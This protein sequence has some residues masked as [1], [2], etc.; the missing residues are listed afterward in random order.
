MNSLLKHPYLMKSLR[1]LHALVWRFL[2]K[3]LI[4]IFPRGRYVSSV[5]NARVFVDFRDENYRWYFRKNRFLEQE[6]I[7]LVEC[8]KLR[9][10]RVIVDIGAHWG[11]FPAM[12]DADIERFPE[13][14]HVICIE[15]DPKNIPILR[16]TVSRITRFKVSIIEAAIG[17]VDSVASAF[18]DGGSCLQTY[19]DRNDAGDLVV[20]LRRLDSILR[21]LGVSDKEVTHIKIDIDGYEPS[22]FFGSREWIRQ[23]KPVILTEYWFKGLAKHPKY[24]VADY[25]SLLQEGH[26]VVLCNYP[27]GTY[28]LLNNS[29]LERLNLKTKN[30][31]ANL[32][33]IPRAIIDVD[34]L[35]KNLPIC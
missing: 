23:F 26:H 21:D 19:S 17:E 3:A 11:I 27:G 28:S 30:S 32:L 13:V 1:S 33:L 6:H 24:H 5:C 9:T 15:P 31:V 35:R 12:L 10:P 4:A 22:F 14:S 8:A 29:D 18:R 16:K 34:T 20:P 7:A 25:F 2:D